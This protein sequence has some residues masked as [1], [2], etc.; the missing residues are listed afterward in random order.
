M[1]IFNPVDRALTATAVLALLVGLSGCG[2]LS[3]A[4]TS[5]PGLG[6]VLPTL[7]TQAVRDRPINNGVPALFRSNHAVTTPS[8]MDPDSVGK[9]LIFI[10]DAGN[11]K[12]V[13]DIFLQSNKNK[14]VGQITGLSPEGIATDAAGNLYIANT[15]YMNVKIYAPPYATAKLTLSEGDNIPRDVAVSTKGLVAVANLCTLANCSGNTG[16]VS[17]FAKGSTT[18]CT[19]VADATNFAHMQNATFDAAGN[20]YVEADGSAPQTWNIGKIVGGCNAKKIELL[21]TP[22]LRRWIG[23]IEID[24][25]HRIAVINKITASGPFYIDTYNPPKNGSLGAPVSITMLGGSNASSIENFAFLRSG[26]DFYDADTQNGSGSRSDEFKYPRNGPPIN[27]IS[28]FDLAWGVAVT[29]T[30]LP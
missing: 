23:G 14:M 19:T 21:T 9:P 5:R 15:G 29:P 2:S 13:V 6:S 24:K 28:G 8:F 4:T 10:S 18:A 26:L 11:N 17:F 1:R 30:L 27:T 12:E 16:S 7:Q 25:A 20:L 3:A 22:N